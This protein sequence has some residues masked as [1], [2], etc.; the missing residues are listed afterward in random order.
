M[1]NL[2]KKVSVLLAYT[3]L[4]FRPDWIMPKPIY[5]ASGLLLVASILTISVIYGL[6]DAASVPQGANHFALV[7]EPQTAVP[8][9]TV[10]RQE[11][12]DKPSSA[13]SAVA[14]PNSSASSRGYDNEVPRWPVRGEVIFEFGWQ[15][16]PVYKDWRYHNGIDIRAT[17]GQPV[18]A[19][20]GGEVQEIYN[21][22]N[23]GQTVAVK[24]GRYLVIYGS[25]DSVAVSKND[26]VSNGSKIGV[27]GS[28]AAEPQVHV[29]LAVKDGDKYINPRSILK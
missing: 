26:T 16:H 24:S 15:E 10:V 23:Y 11:P 7:G 4:L 27:A 29:H 8:K 14:V 5:T 28:F 17:E 21:D 9:E 12:A 6:K 25:L 19:M 13:G 20:L 18:Q 22:K 3:K 1:P 2:P